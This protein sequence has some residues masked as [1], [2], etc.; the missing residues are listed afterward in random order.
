M[1]GSPVIGRRN[2]LSDLKF[3]NGGHMEWTTATSIAARVGYQAYNHR[4]TIQKYWTKAKALADVG[5]TQIVITGHGG[6]R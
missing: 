1:S 2:S 5:D 4:R 6:S 3:V